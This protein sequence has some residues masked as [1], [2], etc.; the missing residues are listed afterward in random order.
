[1]TTSL[2]RTI[3]VQVS[4]VFGERVVALLYYGSRAFG[5]RSVSSASDYDL[6]LVL[7]THRPSDLIELAEV[8]QPHPSLDLSVH[9][10]DELEHWGWHRFQE[11]DQGPFALGYLGASITLLGTNIFADAF[12]GVAADEF[13]RSLRRKVHEYFWRLDHWLLIREHDRSFRLDYRKYLA[14]IAQDLYLVA[15]EM[16]FSDINRLGTDRFLESVG[17]RSDVLSTAT[18]TALGALSDG[19]L[20]IDALVHARL[21]LAADFRRLCADA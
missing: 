20:T 18:K 19:P 15:D 16:T 4:Q 8:T 6:T 10:L 5:S 3:A 13:R 11:G 14:R 12:D 7:D 2:E 1:V 21:Q 17:A 9:F